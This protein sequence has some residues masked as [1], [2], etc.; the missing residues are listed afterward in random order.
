MALYLKIG[1]VHEDGTV[2]Y[3]AIDWLLGSLSYTNT[4]AAR[5]TLSFT[6][7][8][9]DGALI[10]AVGR[11]ILFGDDSLGDL[12]GGTI[13][14]R[15]ASNNPGN[16]AVTSEC[17]CVG[18]DQ[19][20]SKRWT[21][22]R[23]YS[24][25]YAGDVVADLI[26]ACMGGDGFG[27][28][29]IQGPLI[30]V[31][32]SFANL[33][34]ALDTVCQLASDATDTY[35]WDVTPAKVVRFYK[36]TTYPAPF[37]GDA[38]IRI[39]VSSTQSREKLANRVAVRLGKYVGD[40]EPEEYHGDGTAR[41]FALTKPVAEAP[42]IRVNDEDQTVGIQDVD[43]GK[44]WYWSLGSNTVTQDDSGTVLTEDD[45]VTVTYKGWTVRIVEA[46]NNDS[47]TERSSVEGGTGY[48]MQFVSVDDP[49]TYA[50]GLA[51]A[52]ATADAY[53]SPSTSLEI[54]TYTAG[55]RAGQKY[56]FPVGSAYTI[57]ELGID[58]DFLIESVTL[59]DDFGLAKWSAKL[60]RGA[61]IG[62]WKNAFKAFSSHFSGGGSTTTETPTVAAP[63]ALQF[64]PAQYEYGKLSIENI[65]LDGDTAGL[66]GLNINVVYVDELTSDV[67]VELASAVDS[68]TDPLAVPVNRIGNTETPTETLDFE[69]GDWCLFGHEGHYEI[70]QLAAISGPNFTFTRHYPG[71][72]DGEA[73]FSSQMAAHPS[74]TRV[75]KCQVRPFQFDSR[76]GNFA[77]ESLPGRLD[78]D[79]PAACVVA[80]VAA[81]WTDGGYSPW[82]VV[83]CATATLP[84]LRTLTGDNYSFPKSGPLLAN[85][86]VP[87]GVPRQVQYRASLRVVYAYVS[88]APDGADAVLKALRS[89]DGGAT[90][91]D[92]ATVTIPDGEKTSYGASVPSQQMVPYSGSWPFPV[93]FP[94]D[95]LACSVESVGSTDPGAGL[96]LEIYT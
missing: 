46:Q 55:L 76:A 47:I 17:G 28:G 32:F 89:R 82:T 5:D 25:E 40:A 85:A 26:D 24:N 43:T 19:W 79:I 56:T 80:I 60:V 68:T 65:T 35:L 13:H 72:P 74:G 18:W 3:A 63:G 59:T 52:Q 84:G 12:F 51:V 8:S 10:P 9:R 7:V 21:G 39:E 27:S 44:Q 45:R 93:L 73:T 41:Q 96:S 15:K 14:T 36:Q 95:L 2:T 33:Y 91:G 48:Y 64:T 71:T 38:N 92:L 50:D 1:T 11:P 4:I 61:V 70:A 54:V 23:T 30:S 75:Y 81:A 37:S 66:R 87:V 90:W 78:M 67:M 77:D 86:G 62:D 88:T 22:E 58:G 49:S 29:V 16:V 53:G 20:L 31:S 69:V 34:D 94:E 83:N 6:H 42:T 57:P